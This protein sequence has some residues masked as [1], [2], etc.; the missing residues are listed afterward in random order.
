[1]RSKKHAFIHGRK[2]Q[3]HSS[4]SYPADERQQQEAKIGWLMT[5]NSFPYVNRLRKNIAFKG[6][7]LRLSPEVQQ[8]KDSQSVKAIEHVQPTAV[9]K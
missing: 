2:L 4:F 7:R 6:L 5:T 1:M 9:L 8:P 3:A